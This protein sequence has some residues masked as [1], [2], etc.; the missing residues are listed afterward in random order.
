[1]THDPKRPVSPPQPPPMQPVL[2]PLGSNMDR[3][4]ALE[5]AV[6]GIVA[7]SKPVAHPR[8]EE[9]TEECAAIKTTLSVFQLRLATLADLLAR[10]SL[11]ILEQDTPKPTVKKR[12][13][14]KAA[15]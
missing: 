6:N 7:T 12:A 13:A 14:K 9:L 3:I 5:A 11:R 8:I 10:I 1:M 2:R 15:K 4:I